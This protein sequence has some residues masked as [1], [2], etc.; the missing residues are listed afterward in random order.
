[1]T[2]AKPMAVER[3]L[4]LLYFSTAHASLMVAFLAAALWPRAVAGFFY[5]SWLV[6]LVHLVTLGRISLSIVGAFFIVGPIA[7][8]V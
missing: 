3:K 6:G 1:M 5:H 7:Q 2:L 8:R 4:P